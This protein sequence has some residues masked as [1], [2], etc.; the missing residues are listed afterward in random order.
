MAHLVLQGDW[1]EVLYTDGIVCQTFIL[2]LSVS[3]HMLRP[4]Y[5][6]TD[7]R[8]LLALKRTIWGV[9]LSHVVS[10]LLNVL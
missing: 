3:L 7:V 8:C 9:A 5:S 10:L 4:A 6:L 1:E 2:V